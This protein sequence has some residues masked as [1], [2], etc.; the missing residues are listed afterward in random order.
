MKT[1]FLEYGAFSMKI[2]E[3]PDLIKDKPLFN[4]LS[5]NKCLL[6]VILSFWITKVFPTF[7]N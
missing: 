2:R 7:I 3:Y 4:P 6:N 5:P 1:I